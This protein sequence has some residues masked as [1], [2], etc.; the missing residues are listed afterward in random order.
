MTFSFTE[1]LG[2]HLRGPVRPQDEDGRRIHNP[3]RADDRQ[4]QHSLLRRLHVRAWRQS[5]GPLAQGLHTQPLGESRGIQVAHGLREYAAETIPQPHQPLKYA[6][7]LTREDFAVKLRCSD[8]N[9]LAHRPQ[10]IP[11]FICAA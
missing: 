1:F 3:A 8:A 10:L 11:L 7:E 5:A 6:L 2:Q 4:A 9:A